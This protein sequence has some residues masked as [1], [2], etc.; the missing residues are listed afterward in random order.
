MNMMAVLAES[1]TTA[2]PSLINLREVAGRNTCGKSLRLRSTR[3]Y[4]AW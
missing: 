2:Q 1:A 3:E 4:G